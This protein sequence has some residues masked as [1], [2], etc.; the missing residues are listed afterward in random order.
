M[1]LE[2]QLVNDL[3]TLGEVRAPARVLDRVMQELELGDQYALL[4]TLLGPLFVAWN[5]QGISAVMRTQTGAEFE[6]RFGARFGRTVRQAREV[7]CDLGDRFD[8][9]GLSEFEQAVLLKAREIPRGETRTYAEV[10]AGIRASGAIRSVAQA[11]GC[12]PFMII[13][14][15]HR[16][17]EAGNYADQMAP[18]AGVISKRRLLTIEGAHPTVSKTLFEVLLPPVAPTRPHGS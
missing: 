9:R 3:R 6:E 1:L 12:N 10:A 7:P 5:R 14:P 18:H 15:C 17:L 2:R 8:L 11:I 16:V 13:V 4:D